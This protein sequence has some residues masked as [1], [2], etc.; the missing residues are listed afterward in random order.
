MKKNQL[1]DKVFEKLILS[2]SVIKAMKLLS[3]ILCYIY[4]KKSIWCFVLFLP[5]IF[6]LSVSQRQSDVWIRSFHIQ[7]E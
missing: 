4:D 5:Y 2:R 3:I 6:L 1:Q 7:F